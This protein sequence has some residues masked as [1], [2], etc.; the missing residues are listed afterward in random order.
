MQGEGA[1]LNYKVIVNSTAIFLF[2][3]FFATAVWATV[4]WRVFRTLSLTS[5]PVDLVVSP[6]G[7]Y[8]FALTEAGNID[9]YSAAGQLVD[10]I[11]AGENADQ[12]E[13]GPSENVLLVKSRQDSTV[14]IL[15][16]EFIQQ[17]DTAGAPFKGPADAP[18]TVVVFDDFE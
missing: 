7:N 1:A 14:R 12:I 4:E 15:V 11:P 16:L 13:M 8:I 10:R 18:V 5:P 3:L 17:I 2:S 9:I 6:K